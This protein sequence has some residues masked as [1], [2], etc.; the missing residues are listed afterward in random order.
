MKY[1][2]KIETDETPSTGT[3]VYL[4]RFE[5]EDPAAAIRM[6]DDALSKKPRAKRSDAGQSRK[7]DFAEH[8]KDAAVALA[9][10]AAMSAAREG[11]R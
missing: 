1:L 7:I 10:T 6:I 3:L 9:R 8:I 2:I 5:S 4:R 11:A